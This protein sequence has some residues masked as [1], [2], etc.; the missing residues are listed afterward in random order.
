ME[1]SSPQTF[2]R[3]VYCNNDP[4]NKIDPT[5]LMLSDIGVYQTGNPGVAHR[6][7]NGVVRLVRDYVAGRTSQAQER[8]SVTQRTNAAFVASM[9]ASG[10]KRATT[11]WQIADNLRVTLAD[12]GC[13]EYVTKL[14][15]AVSDRFQITPFSTDPRVLVDKIESQGGYRLNPLKSMGGTIGGSIWTD[16]ATVLIAPDDDPNRNL[17]MYYTQVGLHETAHHASGKERTPSSQLTDERLAI[18]TFELMPAERQSRFPLPRRA[19]YP[20]GRGG[21]WEYTLDSSRYWN[22]ELLNNCRAPRR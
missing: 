11:N 7:D 19:N 8:Q 12:P 9:A 18:L 1:L 13:Y 4:V 21:N 20:A 2:N 10:Q 6:L 14:L 3:Y 15:S 16:D 17:M 5:G 22:R